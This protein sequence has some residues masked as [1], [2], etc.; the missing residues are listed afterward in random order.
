MDTRPERRQGSRVDPIAL[1]VLAGAGL[2]AWW[3]HRYQR[4]PERLRLTDG[5]R[6]DADAEVALHVA[7]HEGKQRQ[8]EWLS[9]LH[10]L[11]GLLQD[12][13]VAEAIRRT[14]GDVEA[15]E[16]RVLAALDAHQ[17]TPQTA[18]EAG[19]ILA[20]AIGTSEHTER[21][22]SCTDLWAALAKSGSEAA[23]L[24]EAAG[25]SLVAVLFVL[26]HGEEPEIAE[27]LAGDVH[28]VLR[29]DHYTTRDFVCDVLQQVFALPPA[30]AATRMQT[31]HDHGRAVIGRYAVREARAKILEARRLAKAHGFPLWIGVEPV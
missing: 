3:L 20:Y 2:G 19:W 28:V 11:Y 27:G 9:S 16:D 18:R 26:F 29:N 14:G 13:T 31:T 8:H 10:L 5:S 21:R 12:E 15:L 23:A 7:V 22:A 4:V 1:L 30:E 6:Y 17:V 25:T 24:V